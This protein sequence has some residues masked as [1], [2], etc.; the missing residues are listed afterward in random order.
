MNRNRP[1]PMDRGVFR[2]RINRAPSTVLAA[3]L[4]W[5][6]V[7]LAS[8]LATVL[9]ISSSPVMPPLG[10]L[11]YLAWRQLHPS[12][13]PI[14]AGLPLGLIDDLYSG[15]PFGTGVLAWSLATIVTDVIE[16]R[17]P[18]RNFSTEWT[19]AGAIIA[20]YILFGLLVANVAGG[21]TPMVV[22]VPQIVLSILLYPLVGRIV[23]FLDR[24]RLIP[25]VTVR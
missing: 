23:A 18:W 19:V 6:S 8:V 13:L 15:Q 4:P 16:T 14:W 5:L 24:V 25:I 7:A 21:A 22:I 2:K 12:A 3:A 17:L 1:E 10:F 20:I 11:T 9:V